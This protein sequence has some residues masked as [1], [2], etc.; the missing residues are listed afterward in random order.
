MLPSFTTMKAK[1]AILLGT[2]F[3]VI[4]GGMFVVAR[5]RQSQALAQ[6]ERARAAAL[7]AQQEHQRLLREK[8]Q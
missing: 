3:I 7:H 2:F 6:E 5:T 8:S 4:A 1:Q